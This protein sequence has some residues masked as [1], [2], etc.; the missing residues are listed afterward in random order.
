M[1]HFDLPRNA[2]LFLFRCALSSHFCAF[3]HFSVPSI[4]PSFAL[5]RVSMQYFAFFRILALFLSQR[6]PF[7]SLL[8]PFLFSAPLKPHTFGLFHNC[9]FLWNLLPFLAMLPFS[10]AH[11][12]F[13]LTFVSFF[14]SY[15]LFNLI[16]LPIFSVWMPFLMILRHFAFPRNISFYFHKSA[17]SFHFCVFWPFSQIA[18]PF[19]MHNHFTRF[20]KFDLFFCKCTFHFTLCLSLFLSALLTAYIFPF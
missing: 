9:P 15:C 20:H 13:Q 4:S 12:L 7:I 18:S 3:F 5:L 11:I 16:L 19:P 8:C 2:A 10:F 17:V 14:T 6:C 1:D